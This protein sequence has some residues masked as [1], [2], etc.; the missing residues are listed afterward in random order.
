MKLKTGLGLVVV[1][2]IVAVTLG[3]ALAPEPPWLIHTQIYSVTCYT[4]GRLMFAGEVARR[5]DGDRDAVTGLR[6]YL[7]RWSVACVWREK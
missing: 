2:A 6:L 7:P 1:L 5:W 3:A 4:S